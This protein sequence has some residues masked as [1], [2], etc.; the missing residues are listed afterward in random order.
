MN[1]QEMFQEYQDLAEYTQ[2]LLQKDAQWRRL[3][4]GY[5]RKMLQNKEQMIMKRKMLDNQS[6]LAP[7]RCYTTIGVIKGDGDFD[8]DLRFLGQ[9]VGTITVIDGKPILNVSKKK[10]ETSRREFGYDVGPIDGE[11]WNVG[12]KAKAFKAYYDA[13]I[14]QPDIRPR[15]P[16]HMVPSWKKSTGIQRH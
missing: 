1:R 10:S 11:V 6:H 3:Y 12:E 4:A 13:T 14:E 15:Q 8:F 5:A 16:E 7:L 2:E 9:S